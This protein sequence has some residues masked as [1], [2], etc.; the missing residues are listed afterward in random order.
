MYVG[1]NRQNLLFDKVT[2]LLSKARSE[3]VRSVNKTM[4]YTYFEI[5]RLIIE[6]EQHG[7]DRAEYGK[8]ILKTLSDKLVKEIGKGFSVDNL[9]NMRKFYFAYSKSETVSRNLE[10]YDFQLSWSHYLKLIRI[11]NLEERKFYEIEAIQNNWS[12]RELRRQ[13][14]SALYQRLV[15][16]R[17]KKG[18]KKLS[19]KGQVIETPKDTLKDPYILEFIGLPENTKYSESQLEQKLIDKLEHFLLELGTI[20]EKHFRVDLVFYN[21]ILKSFVIID[22]KIG[23]LKH[24]DIGQ[25]Q[26]YVNYYDR[27]VKLEDE[28]KTI[29]IVL[30]QDKSETLVEITLPQNNEQIFASKYQTILPSKE[31]LKQLIE[32]KDE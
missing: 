26:M 19:E 5:G 17:D 14:D 18:V 31:E 22:L 21:R 24:Q 15:L 4:V 25:I 12:L 10:S 23:E 9:E 8:S 7:K 28:N 29:G 3:V 20:D 30:C 2:Q 27:F 32:N 1:K 11:N 16:S 6:E 13:F